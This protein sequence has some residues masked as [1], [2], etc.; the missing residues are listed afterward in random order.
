M[1]STDSYF[2]LIFARAGLTSIQRT[3]R[4]LGG[5]T[6]DFGNVVVPIKMEEN[7]YHY[8]FRSKHFDLYMNVP[9]KHV[10]GMSS[11]SQ[12]VAKCNSVL[13]NCFFFMLCTGFW[14]ACV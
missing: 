10:M 11:N 9:D 14:C 1:P 13:N 8:C 6:T 3:W 2:H 7:L 5:K 4:K 12:F